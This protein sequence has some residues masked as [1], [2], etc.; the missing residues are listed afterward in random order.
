MAKMMIDS[1]VMAAVS[2]LKKATAFY[3]KLGLRPSVKRPYYVE[4]PLPGG[5]VLGLHSVDRLKRTEPRA[6]R[7]RTRTGWGILLRVRD[8]QGFIGE[9][10]RKGIDCTPVRK[11]PGGANF[12]YVFDP[13][14]NRFVLLEME[15]S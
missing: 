5:T 9:L 13:E 7:R 6:G 12:S 14:G 8:L 2:D 1:W 4:Y 11:A 3:R 15:N 10:Q